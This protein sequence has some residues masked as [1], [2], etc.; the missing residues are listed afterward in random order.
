MNLRDC[1]R[2]AIV[3]CPGSGKSMLSLQ[4]ARFCDLPLIHLDRE[5]WQPGWKQP[6]AEDWQRRVREL[7][8]GE[9]WIIDGNYAGTLPLRLE[10]ADTVIWLDMPLAVCLWGVIKRRFMFRRRQRPD[11]ASHCPERLR[12]SFFKYILDFHKTQL[13]QLRRQI[14]ACNGI[15]R[16]VFTRRKDVCQW[17][18]ALEQCNAPSAEEAL[19]KTVRVIMDRPI[20]TVHP[21]HPHI[22]YPINYGYA[23]GLIGGDG[24]GQDVYVLGPKTPLAEFSGQIIGVV[25]RFNDTEDKWIAAPEGLCFSQKEMDESVAFQ[26]QFYDT[27]ILCRPT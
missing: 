12:L 11:M 27:E 4:L 22:H 8:E 17:L 6:Q 14:D 7:T 1:R 2:I 5:Y 13:P 24:E 15:N 16:L 18:A 26:E 10:R 20:G 21:K 3:G 19:G 23:E 25:H 9:R